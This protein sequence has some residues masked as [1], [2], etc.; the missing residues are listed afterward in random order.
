[1]TYTPDELQVLIE[2]IRVQ[3]VKDWVPATTNTSRHLLL[4]LLVK[5]R[6]EKQDI[7]IQH[8]RRERRKTPNH[9]LAYETYFDVTEMLLELMYYTPLEDLPLKMANSGLLYNDILKW[10]LEMGK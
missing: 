2:R 4:E 6:N 7:D 5:S 1:M 3:Q 8:V 10:R 9:I